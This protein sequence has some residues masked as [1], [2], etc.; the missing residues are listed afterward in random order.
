[1]ETSDQSLNPRKINFKVCSEC[2]I[3]VEFKKLNIHWKRKHPDIFEEFKKIDGFNLEIGTLPRNPHNEWM[4]KLILKLDEYDRSEI[5]S[6]PY[7]WFLR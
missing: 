1:M 3:S 4:D 6:D 7:W 2:G 5:K